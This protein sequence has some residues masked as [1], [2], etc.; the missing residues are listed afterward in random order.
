MG[1]YD[2]DYYRG[3]NR[4]P[5]FFSTAP[6][7]KWLIIINVAIFLAEQLKILDPSLIDTWFAANADA[8]F[9]QGR[10]WQLLTATFLHA[11]VR[12]LL[13]NMLILWFAGREMEAVYGRRDFLALYLSAAVFTTL[14][15]AGIHVVP[16]NDVTHSIA[17]MK[18][19]SGA[20][21]TVVVLCALIYPHKEV[22]LFGVIPMEMWLLV[23]VYVGYDVFMLFSG[24]SPIALESHLS[25]VAYGFLYKHFDLRWS[26]LPWNRARR[27]KLRIV[28]GGEPRETAKPR[29]ASNSKPS[30]APNSASVAKPAVAVI[31][32]EQLDARL[33]EVLAKIARQGREGLTEEEN[34]ILQEAS[35][36][37]RNRRSEKL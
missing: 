9:K 4:G 31:A 14:V 25:G 32:E 26:H 28:T 3:E 20:I 19:A 18:G 11:D 10:I 23:S 37:A 6:V 33:D 21:L 2:R 7:C 1:I 17:M 24:G 8:I 16:S 27:P 30:W 5:G 15:W 22:V 12:H 34:K 36:R 35:R 13:G 29:P